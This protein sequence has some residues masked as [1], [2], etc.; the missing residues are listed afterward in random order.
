M[1]AI[2]YVSFLSL[3]LLFFQSFAWSNFVRIINN[4]DIPLQFKFLTNVGGLIPVLVL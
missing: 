1:K 4:S 3:I 2:K